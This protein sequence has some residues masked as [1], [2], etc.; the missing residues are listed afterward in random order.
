MQVVLCTCTAA[1]DPQIAALPPFDL[2]LLDE[3]GQA[4]QPNGLLPLLRAPRAVL[5]GDP[6]QLPPTVIGAEAAAEA[7][8]TMHMHHA[9]RTCTCTTHMHMHHAHAHA[10]CTHAHTL[11]RT[12]CRAC[13][14]N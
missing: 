11:A 3:A 8:A 10:P 4:T 9:P 6:M 2:A 7:H 5:V 12:H 1:A 13:S 14:W